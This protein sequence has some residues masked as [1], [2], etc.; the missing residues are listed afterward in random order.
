MSARLK[1]ERKATAGNLKRATS[2]TSQFEPRCVVPP[3]TVG[4]LAEVPEAS[5][6][7]GYFGMTYLSMFGVVTDFQG[8]FL[9]MPNAHFGVNV[10]WKSIV[11][12]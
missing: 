3:I 5:D 8:I 4:I 6:W 10:F 7:H 12:F 9:G 2:L 1:T 11:K